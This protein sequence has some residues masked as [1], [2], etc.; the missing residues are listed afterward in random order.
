MKLSQPSCLNEAF[1]QNLRLG[2]GR[3]ETSPILKLKLMI[4]PAESSLTGIAEISHRNW[5]H[6]NHTFF[7]IVTGSYTHIQ[8]DTHYY[9]IHLRGWIAPQ[10]SP[11]SPIPSSNEL[12]IMMAVNRDWKGKGSFSFGDLEIEN[13][14]VCSLKHLNDEAL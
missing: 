7:P 12:K 13:V 10:A 1:D 9:L 6:S 4:V 8:L 3:E 11:T 2:V 14:C 5:G